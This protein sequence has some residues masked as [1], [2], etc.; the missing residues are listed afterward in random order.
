MMVLQASSLL[1]LIQ[2]DKRPR[3]EVHGAANIG[4]INHDGDFTL[5]RLPIGWAKA[6]DPLTFVHEL[7]HILGL[8]HN[9]EIMPGRG[10]MMLSNYGYIMRG[11]AKDGKPGM[12]TIMA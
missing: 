10:S 6:G 7:G 4:H 8:N 12:I 5:L 9:R 1:N 11:S 3:S 2:A